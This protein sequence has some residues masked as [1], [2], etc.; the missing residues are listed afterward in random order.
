MEVRFDHEKL[1]VYQAAVKFSGWSGTLVESLNG[2][3]AVEN[4]LDCASTSLVL[5]IAEGNGKRSQRDRCRF[6]DIARGSAVEYAAC[7]DVLCVRG[8]VDES[9]IDDGKDQLVGI[10]SMI[11]GLISRFGGNES[12]SSVKEDQ[13]AYGSEDFIEN[14]NKNE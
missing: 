3:L 2:K 11:A 6:L 13:S 10:V 8:I 5:N 1:R 14:E 12:S 7:L 4:Q 9:T